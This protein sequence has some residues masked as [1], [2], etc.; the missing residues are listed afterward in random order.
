LVIDKEYG[1]QNV[2]ATIYQHL[3]IDPNQTFPNFSGR[4]TYLLDDH[5]PIAELL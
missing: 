2:L 3:G 1:A 4:P 5:R